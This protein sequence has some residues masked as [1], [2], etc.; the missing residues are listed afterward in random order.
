MPY[1]KWSD[2]KRKRTDREP[3]SELEAAERA[4]QRLSAIADCYTYRV[5]WS[6]DE[7]AFIGL[8]AEMPRLSH[9]DETREAACTGIRGL[10]I[11]V[12][13]DMLEKGETLPPIAAGA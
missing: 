4:A 13:A 6:E 10:V 2:I 12:L 5:I 9:F 1:R 8:C 11:G 7:Q 3:I